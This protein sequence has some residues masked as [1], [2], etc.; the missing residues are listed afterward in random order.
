MA[1]GGKSGN[2]SAKRVN[3]YFALILGSDILIQPGRNESGV[4]GYL[5]TDG[6]PS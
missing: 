5:C 4:W 2:W 6:R 3:E 1:K